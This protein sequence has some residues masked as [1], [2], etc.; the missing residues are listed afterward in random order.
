MSKTHDHFQSLFAYAPISLWEEDYSGIKTFFDDLRSRGVTDLGQHFDAHPQ[1]VDACMKR[2]KV[3]HVNEETLAMFDADSEK[4]LLDNLDKVFRDEMRHHFRDE[5]LTLWSGKIN[6]SGEG[7]NYTLKGKPLNI[8]LHWRILPECLDEWECVMVAIQDITLLKRAEARFHHLFNHA[9]ISLWEEDYREIKFLFEELRRQGVT[10]LQAHLAGHPE[11]VDRFMGMIHVLDVNQKTLDLFGASD[12]A[13]LLANLD[14]VF[15]DDMRAHFSG[16]LVDMWNGKAAYEREGINYA[17]SGDPFNVHLDWRLMPGHEDD[18]EWVLVALQDISARKKAEEYLRY[19]GT[20]DVMTG[21]HNR[22]YFEEQLARL[23]DV[24]KLGIIMA[25]LDGL[26][27]VN[28]TLG[29]QA[30]DQFI[31]RAAEVLKSATGGEQ[32]VA[33]VGGD[34]FSILM[35]NCSE[36]DVQ[37]MVDRISSLIPINNKFYQ[38]PTL[39]ISI[40]GAMRRDMEPLEKTMARADDLMYKT[41]SSHHENSH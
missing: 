26:K 15:R 39:N 4:E 40:G 18:F 27:Q 41:K 14:K 20:H 25:D 35:P 9:P 30:G 33:R 21:L 11:L 23:A 19:L 13:T 29:H 1:D 32:V 34:E 2:I 7:I 10:D 5:L 3:L 36:E 16:E 38:G 12:K 6:W 22:A 24:K 17:L 31:R 8:R 28:D 37:K